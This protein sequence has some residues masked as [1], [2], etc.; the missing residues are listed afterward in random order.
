MLKTSDIEMRL[1]QCEPGIFQKICNEILCRYG[2]IP[3]KYTGSVSGSN[4]TKLGTPDSVFK[5]QEKKYVYVEITTQKE[6][7]ESKIKEDVI[8][9]LNKIS[10]SSFLAGKISKIIFMHNHENPD[11]IITEKIKQMCKDIEFE[12]YDISWLSSILQNECKD[13]AISLLGIKDDNQSIN[14]LSPDA[15]EQIANIIQQNQSPK[16]KDNTFEEIKT[17]INS[18]YEEAISIINNDDALIH[19]S[20]K[21]KNRLKELYNSLKDFDFYYKNREDENAK[22]YYHNMLVILSKYDL[23]L[24]IDFYNKMPSFAKN[25][26][27]TIHF[28]S[29]ILIEKE[30]YNEAQKILEDLYFNKHYENAF[31][32]LVKAYFLEKNYEKVISIL[33]GAKADKFDSYGFLAAML[34]ISKNKI[35]KYSENEILRL[36]NSKFRNMPLFY[37]C[38]AK[39][40]YDIDKKSKKYKSQFKKGL[41]ILNKKDVISIYTMCNQALEIN[42]EEYAISFLES[43]D[44]TSYVLQSKLLELL[45]RNKELSKWEIDFVENINFDVFDESFDIDFFKAR[46]SEIKGK[47]LESIKSYRKSFE[48]NS[49]EISAYKYI[50][51]SIKNKTGID[52]SVISFMA[53]LNKID[54]LVIAA[55]AY[56]HIGKYEEAKYCSYK[57]IYLAKNNSKY[58]EVFK[59]FWYTLTL[60]DADEEE[61]I[62]YVSKNCVVILTFKRYKKIILLEDDIYFKENDNF[63]GAI[64]ARTYSET[65]LKLLRKKKGEKVSLDKKEFI[66]EEIFN[67]YTYF[68]RVSFKH[69]KNCKHF[70]SFES[71]CDKIEESLEQIKKE[72]LEMNNS[73]N[74]QLDIYQNSGDIPLSGLLS[75]ENNFE[76]YAQLIKTLLSEK[77]R[78]LFAGENINVDLSDGFVLDISSMILLS[79]FDILDLIPENFYSKIYVTSSLKNNFQY[80]YNSL[81]RKEDSVEKSLY[82]S[83]GDKLLLNEIPVIEQIKFWKKLNDLINKINVVDIESEKDN[84]L[85]DTTLGF[86]DKVQFDLMALAKSKDIPFI[87]DDLAIR[88]IANTYEI[89]H[90]NSIQIV[91]VFSKDYEEYISILIKLSKQN[92]IYTLY[93]DSLLEMLRILYRNFDE[94]NKELFKSIIEAVLDSKASLDYYVPILLPIIEKSKEIQYI[95]IFGQVH[96]FLFATFFIKNIYGLI[97]TQ[98]SKYGVDINR[99]IND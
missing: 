96:E 61:N 5:N 41:K 32:T 48:K 3:Y 57:A 83:D 82:I 10:S 88:K 64:I 95:K 39:L 18:L 17:K 97:E 79:I 2:Y 85:N 13:I 35:K 43:I 37:F 16:F 65:G 93:G 69:I 22:M 42:L 12:I 68:A 58:Q 62:N 50:Y 86:L 21:N 74:R 92:Y 53:N 9:C 20:Y 24:G 45:S 67:K 4:K 98:C 14:K 60:Y 19:I 7:K 72:M 75:K 8:K 91:K 29:I 80:F 73:R 94:H 71:S 1:L 52:E 84:L 99:Y 11:E 63:K 33:S 23:T 26:Y 25:N 89:R 77:E 47:E 38:T 31:E 76:E 81:I 90:T 87:C 70:K 46:I 44:S 27:L 36:N 34:I 54:S 6:N 28:Y 78:L 59:Q 49:N 40:L 66:V 30:R 56:K 51:L 15:I 55:D